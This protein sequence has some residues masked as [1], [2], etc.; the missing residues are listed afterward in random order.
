MQSSG[1]SGS[2]F[3]Y[4]KL[5]WVRGENVMR[6]E[7]YLSSWELLAWLSFTLHVP[8]GSSQAFGLHTASC[9]WQQ[10]ACQCQLA[11]PGY[12]AWYLLP[13][14][15]LRGVEQGACSNPFGSV[16][17]FA[18]LQTVSV[19]GVPINEFAVMKSSTHWGLDAHCAEAH[20]ALPVRAAALLA[21]QDRSLHSTRSVDLGQFKSVF[22]T[23]YLKTFVIIFWAV[24]KISLD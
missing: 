10:G 19:A 6:K 7:P 17:F 24:L 22:K 20:T 1:A 5:K 15:S 11:A 4:L 8:S 3:V 13:R 23:G 16:W 9:V 18:V 14:V 2:N 21:C 12:P